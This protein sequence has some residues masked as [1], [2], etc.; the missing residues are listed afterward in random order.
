MALV[1]GPDR[2][3]RTVHRLILVLT[4]SVVLVSS[5]F[6]YEYFS[7]A[8]TPEGGCGPGCPTL[9]YIVGIPYAVPPGG[10]GCQNRTGE[11][12]FE[13]SFEDL[14]GGAQLSELQFSLNTSSGSAA[15]TGESALVTA[16]D[17][18]GDVV[19]LWN[20]TSGTW[21]AGGAWPLPVNQNVTLTFDSGLQSV[22]LGHDFFFIW[23]GPPI[24]SA[25]GVSL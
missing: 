7:G 1:A 21:H 20:W 9:S 14:V 25:V 13:L 8:L 18:A 6:G 19:G 11:V 15:P 22:S 3:R 10:I 2:N 4:I 24:R 5:V 17:G 12:C 16:S 23:M